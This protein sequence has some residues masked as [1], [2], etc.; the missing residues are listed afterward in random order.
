MKLHF[1]HDGDRSVG[2]TG[3][4]VTVQFDGDDYDAEYIAAA[5]EL[6]LPAFQELF[7]FRTHV[8]TEDE[9]RDTEAR[10]EAQHG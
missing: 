8:A 10:M 2:I 9:L 7:D 5:K 1:W 3:D 4:S 6:L